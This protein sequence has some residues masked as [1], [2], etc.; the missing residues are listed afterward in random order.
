MRSRPRPQGDSGLAVLGLIATLVVVVAAAGLLQRTAWTAERINEKA[1]RIARTGRGINESTD[2]II[3]LEKT[4][5]LA[6]SILDSASPL[7]GK[8]AEI[9]RLAGSV[10]GLAGTING[11][12]GSINST[13]RSINSTAGAI[14]STAGG[15]NN[16][17]AQIL[18]VAK[19]I[20]RGVELI[21]L[22]L[23]RTIAIAKLI[24]SDT[25]N[26][27]TEAQRAHVKAACIDRGL[28]GARGA[29]G[30]CA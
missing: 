15:I 18:D 16:E 6:T 9:V 27:V 30:D 23:D 14:N 24:R 13:A 4:N 12:A 2:A 8:L 17:A 26:L 7:Q 25:T 3:Q 1:E 20:N 11:S 28:G 19:R 5:A 10:N 22:N 29:D 21:N